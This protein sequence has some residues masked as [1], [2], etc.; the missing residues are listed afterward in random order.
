ML[1]VALEGRQ[2]SPIQLNPT[3]KAR[4]RPATLAATANFKLVEG[5][6]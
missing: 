1:V 3:Y 4:T 6:R 5:Q 2:S